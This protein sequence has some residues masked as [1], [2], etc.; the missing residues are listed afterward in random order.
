VKEETTGQASVTAKSKSVSGY[1]YVIDFNAQPDGSDLWLFSKTTALRTKLNR[2]SVLLS[3]SENARTWY[4]I[5]SARHLLTLYSSRP[6]TISY[7]LTAPRFDEEKWKNVT[8]NGSDGLV[9][10]DPDVASLNDIQIDGNGNVGGQL[11]ASIG[12]ES[13]FQVVDELGTVVEE[14]VLQ[15]K[16]VSAHIVAGLISAQ[17]I[18]SPLAEI[19]TLTVNKKLV[20]PVIETSEIRS[21][22]KDINVT[23]GNN[24]GGKLSQLII[25]GL[26]NA[27]AASID[28]E[29]NA[30]F[31]GTLTADSVESRKSK[32]ESLDAINASVSGTLIAKNIQS[33]IIDQLSSQIASSTSSLST[34]YQLLSTNINSVQQELASIK[35]QPLPNPA[36][37]QN[38]DASY[39]NIT[40]DDTANIYKAHITDSLSVGSL[41]IQSS[42][43]LALSNDL[44][45]S[46]LNTIHLFDDAVMIAKNGNMTIKGEITASTLAIKNTNGTTVASI[47]PSGSAHF[48]EVV[49]KKF[50]LESI[51]TQG[52]LVADSGLRNAENSPIPGIKTSTEVAGT[53]TLPIDTKEIVI[54][55]DNVTENSLIYLTPTTDNIQGQLS[56]T[57]K[58]S[59]LSTP[60][61]QSCTPYFMV[62]STSAIHSASEFNWLIIN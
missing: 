55:N 57:K 24:S 4:K 52:A 17:K 59:C 46:S 51:A 54:Y 13:G 53:G 39:S 8:P 34:N 22:G 45:I 11:V 12:G 28:A 48:N 5:D 30:T 50:T 7:R 29:G 44:Y 58:L 27:P 47:D 3:P 49:A 33:D 60:T 26:N 42:S 41:I 21:N 23:L 2:M 19:D 32:V 37:Y 15:A 18:V 56:V 25:N 9:V 35:S 6:T 43:V 36:Y 31:A 20:S 14:T 16:T 10:T 40:V 61:P 38:I 1:E 62:S